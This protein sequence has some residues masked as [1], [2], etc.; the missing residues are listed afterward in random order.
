MNMSIKPNPTIDD[1]AEVPNE[2]AIAAMSLSE[3]DKDLHGPYETVAKM[4][5]DLNAE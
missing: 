3:Q 4:M 2:T 1:I 5:E